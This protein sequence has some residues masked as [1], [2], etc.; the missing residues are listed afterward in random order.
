[1]QSNNRK[2]VFTKDMPGEE[3]KIIFDKANVIIF[4]DFDEDEF[5]IYLKTRIY[6][7]EHIFWQ[8]V[9]VKKLIV[10]KEFIDAF[11]FYYKYILLPLTELLRIKYA[12]RK[13]LF[14]K[15]ISKDLPKDIYITLESL[16]KISSFEEMLTK[17]EIANKLF[18]ETINELK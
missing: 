12:P 14:L 16:Y 6:H 17:I 9:K 1:M 18:S 10:R 5:A 8:N 11:H 4:K 3:V 2:F 7:L 13:Q 15:Y